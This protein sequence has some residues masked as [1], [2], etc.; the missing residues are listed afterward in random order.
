LEY[1]DR[2]LA[3]MS[4]ID[5]LTKIGNHRTL[6]ELLKAEIVKA[7][8][9][10][11]PLSIVIFDVDNFKKIND[12]KGHVYGDQVLVDIAAIMKK[13]IRETDF[14][15]RYGG[16]EFMVIFPNTLLS[17]AR[18]IAERIRQAV[19]ENI[20]VDEISINISGGVGQYN[21][22]TITELIHAAD[23]KLYTAKRN[24]K[25]QVVYEI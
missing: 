21:N 25:N 14:V 11:N 8:L 3:E 2:I 7:S 13:N 10:R 24:G 6:M 22:E 16:E 4:S 12:S 20:F 17:V 9:T 5:G 23:M 18:V 15:G 19:E 1:K